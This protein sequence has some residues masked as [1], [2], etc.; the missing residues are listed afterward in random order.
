MPS[1]PNA[2]EA[3]AKLRSD[4]SHAAFASGLLR[5]D[6]LIALFIGSVVAL[7]VLPL[8]TVVLDGLISLNLAASVIL[9]TISI[10]LPSALS[11]SSFPS[12]LLF[13]T[14]FRL[15]L[16]IA[17]CK[18][19]LLQANAGHVIDT[20]GKLVVGGNVV[21][22]GVVFTVIAIVQFVVIAK[23]S[24]RV[25]E[26]GARFTLDAMPGKQMSIDADL[27]AGIITSD[28]AK[29]RRELLE[30]ESQLHGAMDGAMKFVKGG[31]I[32]GILIAV[33]NILAGIA[34]GAL[35]H[36]MS[37]A[38]ALHR[39]AVL[40]VGDGMASQI[41]SLMVSIAAGVVTTRV[42][43]REMNDRHLGQLIGAQIAAH[44]RGLLMGALVLFAFVLVPGMPKWAFLSLALL[45]GASAIHFLRERQ[46]PPVLNLLSVGAEGT[47]AQ[48][49]RPE[50]VSAAAGIAAPVA[51]RLAENLRKDIK[52]VPLQNALARSKAAV[53]DDIGLVF[54]RVHL[55]YSAQTLPNHYRIYVQDVFASEGTLQV[56]HRLWTEAA[57][58]AG[59]D[60]ES[61]AAFGPF[62]HAWW[63]TM[64]ASQA[65]ETAKAA[66][67]Q[68]LEP[69]QVVAR[70]VE[71]VIRRHAAQMVGI[72]E[73]QNMLQL[74]RRDR[75]ELVGELT[76][77]VPLQRVT[78][79]L[80]RLLDE[81]IPIRNLNTILESL[82][83][84]SPHEP[85]DVTMLVEL[86]RMD[87]R[88]QI[89]DHFCGPDRSLNVV[90]FEQSLQERIE[91]AVV[92]TKQGNLLGLS[93]EVRTNIADQVQNVTEA[94]RHGEATAGQP[95]TAIMVAMT[96]RAYVRRLI[97]ATLPDLPVVSLQEIEADVQ[98]HTVGWVRN[99]PEDRP[100]ADPAAAAGATA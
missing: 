78:D 53:E 79:V 100:K 95:R 17:S 67:G 28:Q 30:Q 66:W 87:L 68:A 98:L 13:T 46:A 80:R 6:L 50:E 93:R 27:R 82:I 48:P 37:V 90:L 51:V 3:L 19:I 58:P 70:H 56:A 41:P 2:Q 20:F 89:T 24:E 61:T 69:E 99:P 23:G 10:Y 60:A 11:F 64:P 72:Q 52:L 73:V 86:V 81:G 75:A 26:V 54:P 34:V 44:P 55:T 7:F 22:G 12:L 96:C 71:A 32:A 39:Y 31:A 9:L 77:L 49:G 65:D 92:R 83:A 97:E 76:R 38:D 59:V 74:V 91:D 42:S 88:R 45:A 47:G 29:H 14:L 94:A 15:S 4:P 5:Y 57:P 62:N 8:P 35:M 33:I 16:N 85:D 63:M 1:I 25:A 21:V 84:R 40:T 18:L 36:D 43:S